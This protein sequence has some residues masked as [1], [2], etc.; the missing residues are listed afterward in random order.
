MSPSARTALLGAVLVAVG[1]GGGFLVLWQ[2]ATR[3]ERELLR[4]EAALA[5]VLGTTERPGGEL[6]FDGIRPFVE[7]SDRP[8]VSLGVVY[9]MEVDRS[10]KMLRG[11]INPRLFASIAPQYRRLVLEGREQVLRA[12]A[13]GKVERAGRIREL[14]VGGRLKL[15]FDLARIDREVRALYTVGGAILGGF[16]LVGIALVVLLTRWS[17]APLARLARQTSAVAVGEDLH[18]RIEIPGSGPVAQVARAFDQIRAEL[19][20]KVDAREVLGPYLGESVASRILGEASPLEIPAEERA[21]TVLALGLRG[22]ST[23]E[24]GL[25]PG[26][27]LRA[28]NEYF[29]PVIDALVDRAGSVVQLCGPRLVAVWGFPSPI[30]EPERAAI[31][32]ALAARAAARQEGRR[33]TAIGGMVLDPCVGIASGRAVGGNLGSAR[34]VTYTVSGGAVELATLIEAQA[35]PGEILVNEAAFDKVRGVVTGA[36][37]APLMAEGMEEAVPLYRLEG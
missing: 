37:C 29:A 33:Q 17:A 27:A 14:A 34:R 19:C 31:K 22:L 28:I 18:R 10:G 2:S 11:A 35:Q 4:G 5:R 30:K 26:E 32:A 21:V 3:I 12:L 8:D 25:A 6:D 23:V 20:D 24:S 15:G 7:H 13:A 9:A 16:L 36:A 1:C